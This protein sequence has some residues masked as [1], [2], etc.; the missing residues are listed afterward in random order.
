M[1]EGNLSILVIDEP[2]QGRGIVRMLTNIGANIVGV[3]GYG[4]HVAKIVRTVEHD[5]IIVGLRE[6]IA[7]AA[8]SLE[9]VSLASYG[10]PVIAYT[11]ETKSLC[12]PRSYP[13]SYASRGEGRYRSAY[14]SR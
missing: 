3:Y 4:R 12:H 6:P 2:P 8:R 5:V 9:L 11:E 14:Q 7:R 1:E 10:A 13:E